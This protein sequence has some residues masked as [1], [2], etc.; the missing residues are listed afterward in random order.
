MAP[1]TTCIHYWDIE[2]AEGPS[3][4]GTC[5]YC[6]KTKRFSNSVVQKALFTHIDVPRDQAEDGDYKRVDISIGWRS[7]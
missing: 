3:S 2:A 4:L 1:K 7:R 5:R 6:S